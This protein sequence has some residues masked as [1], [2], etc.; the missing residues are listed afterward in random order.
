MMGS[1]MLM[2]VPPPIP[3][4]LPAEPTNGGFP[5]PPGPTTIAADAPGFGFTVVFSPRNGYT[6]NMVTSRLS[7]DWWILFFFNKGKQL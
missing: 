2:L 6:S 7:F 4:Q 1:C 3:Q 5:D